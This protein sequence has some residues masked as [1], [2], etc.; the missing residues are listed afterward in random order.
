MNCLINRNS[1]FVSRL[2]SGTPNPDKA[3]Q[4]KTTWTASSLN[5]QD[6]S[7]LNSIFNKNQV[8]ANEEQA[9][10]HKT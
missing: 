2:F 7:N 3:N 5:Q 6:F 4:L 9:Y 8:S 1:R 10:D